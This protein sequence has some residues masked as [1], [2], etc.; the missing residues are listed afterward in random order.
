MD[1]AAKSPSGR[2]A[3]A[4]HTGKWL[5]PGAAGAVL[6]GGIVAVLVAFNVGGVRGDA[7]P[8]PAIRSEAPAVPQA[9]VKVPLAPEARRVAGRFILT[10]VARKNLAEAYQLVA[11]SL[12]RGMTLKQ[13]EQGN[14]PVVPYPTQELK[15]V[16]MA[17]DT[18][19]AEDASIRVFLD[20]KAGVKVKPQIFYLRMKKFGSHW[21]VTGW[22]PYNA[23]PIPLATS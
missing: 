11:P 21:L 8:G 7:K 9:A 20:P 10:A 13:W 18:S 5:L 17:V 23:I 3:S 14:I 15:P 12:K 2:K 4:P 16:H 6:V 22:V 19:T 1:P